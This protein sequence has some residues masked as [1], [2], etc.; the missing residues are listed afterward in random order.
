MRVSSSCSTWTRIRSPSRA[1]ASASRRV[2]KEL[3]WSTRV[4]YQVVEGRPE[5]LDSEGPV[6]D[7]EIKAQMSTMRRIAP[8]PRSAPTFTVGSSCCHFPH[9]EGAGLRFRA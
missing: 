3:A 8:T 4:T 9:Q 2:L 5:F 7:L 6:D 1:L